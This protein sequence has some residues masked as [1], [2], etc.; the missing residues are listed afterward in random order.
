MNL[1]LITVDSLRA[2]HVGCYGYDRETTPN[3]DDLASQSHV[4]TEAA[5]H[6]CATRPSFPSLLTST[7]G[8]LYGGFDHLSE[9]QVPMAVP[10]SE[11]GYATAGFH[12]NPFLSA[13]FGYNRGFDEF[14][15]SEDDPT[16]VSRLRKYVSNNLDGR[17]HDLLSWAHN[18]AEEHAGVDVGAYY[19]NAASLTDEALAWVESAEEPWFLWIHYMDP[20]HP[21]IPPDEHQVFG[22]T[23]S[24]RR[25]VKLRQQVLDDPDALSEQDW[26][27]LVDLYDA[28]IRYTDAEIGRLV[29]ALD[30]ATWVLTAD[31]GEEF[32]EHGNFGH[33]NRF[34]EE[35]VHVPFLLGGTDGSGIHDHLVGLN[36]VPVTLLSEAGVD[37]P[38]TYRGQHVLSGD[39]ERVVGGWAPDS[40]GDLDAARLMSRTV[41]EKYIRN[42]E[43][44]TEELYDLQ[45]DPEEQTD[46]SGERDS[47]AHTSALD[48]FLDEIRRTS[49][50]SETV[51]VGEELEEQLEHLGYK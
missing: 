25:G 51:E 15:D 22:E 49:S 42:D 27:D 38:E 9:E 29:D 23:L 12:S 39:R 43:R 20:H 19:Q 34:Y 14:S 50:R 26:S 36:D 48:S 6:A 30:D 18:K 5:S 46:R 3:I 45:N 8:M 10:L 32:Y 24:R 37:V 2:D 11:G 16:L 13:T 41:D 44:G 7:H 4:F 47:R 35:H 21:Y 17:L 33:K 28:E 40:G 1:A 31:H